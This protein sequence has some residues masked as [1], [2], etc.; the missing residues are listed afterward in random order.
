MI[1]RELPAMVVQGLMKYT[2]LSLYPVLILI[3]VCK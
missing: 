1:I 2:S 3:K